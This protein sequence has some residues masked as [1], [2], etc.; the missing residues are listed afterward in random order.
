MWGETAEGRGNPGSHG[1][2]DEGERRIQKFQRHKS[3]KNKISQ[4]EREG[5]KDHQPQ[6]EVSALCN[7]TGTTLYL[8]LKT[9]LQV[10]TN[11]YEKSKRQKKKIRERER[12]RERERESKKKFLK[13]DLFLYKIIKKKTHHQT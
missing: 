2:R 7:R 1:G 4:N 12:A 13:V 5:K 11:F 3:N 8:N 6:V 9:C 10:A